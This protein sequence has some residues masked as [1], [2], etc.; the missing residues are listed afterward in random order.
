[1]WM[2]KLDVATTK[3]ST[4]VTTGG[5]ADDE[6]GAPTNHNYNHETF[7]TAAHIRV[8][9]VPGVL[10]FDGDGGGDAATARSDGDDDDGGDGDAATANTASS[11][12]VARSEGRPRG[13]GA[14]TAGAGD[15]V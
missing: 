12:T 9:L 10:A 7:P 2:Y 15:G 3:V 14:G 1:M 13:A 5:E 6:L 8:P 4:G 11:E